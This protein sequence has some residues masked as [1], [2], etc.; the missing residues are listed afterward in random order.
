MSQLTEFVRQLLAENYDLGDVKTVTAIKA[1]DT[2][3]SFL[4]DCEKDG[5]SRRWYVRQYNPSAQERDLRFEHAFE[6]YFTEHAAGEVQTILPLQTKDGG[7]WVRTAWDGTEN[8][9]AVF[10][11]LSGREPYSW[12]YND[13]S[14][15]ALDSCAEMTGKFHVW[16]Y[17]FEKPENSGKTEPPM[18][19]VFNVWRED[20]PKAFA[21]K[22]KNPE[23]FRRFNDYFRHEIPYLMKMIDYCE[24]ELAK[25]K[26]G[27]K[28]CINHKDFN[29]GNVMF[30]E[31]D[32][33]CAI[34]DMDWCNEDY[35]LYDIGWMGYQAIASWDTR[36][37]GAIPVE[38]IGRFIRLYDQVME[39]S[40]CPLGTLTEEEREFLPVMMM[41]GI[42]KVIIDFTCYEDHSEEVHRMFVN[43]WR[44]MDSVHFIDEHMDEIKAACK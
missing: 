9:Y 12:E 42:I 8:F 23:V 10:N 41:I 22:E 27:L 1:G 33:I 43:T 35:R 11:T 4:S 6:V 25:Y 7:T 15:N 26:S 29:P 5:E 40:G 2:N 44:F 13:L 34:F 21:E 32:R 17:G 24:G 16:G 36:S 3:N 39:E 18:E 31:N 20:I 19:E 14:Q 28:K 30:D 37:W 38:R